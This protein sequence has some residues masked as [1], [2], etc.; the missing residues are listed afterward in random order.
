[1]ILT[2][3]SWINGPVTYELTE[4]DM[5]TIYS[6]GYQQGYSDCSYEDEEQYSKG[7]SPVGIDEDEVVVPDNIDVHIED[8]KSSEYEEE[9]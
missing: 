8:Y 7:R 9:E 5:K 4:D 6:Q 3:C 1:M 2:S